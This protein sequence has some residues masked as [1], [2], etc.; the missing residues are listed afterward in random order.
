MRKA[1]LLLVVLAAFATFYACGGD[2]TEIPKQEIDTSD[3]HFVG[4][5]IILET[6]NQNPPPGWVFGERP[7]RGVDE[8]TGE[9]EMYFYAEG[10]SK[11][12]NLAERSARGNVAAAA[13]ESI[14]KNVLSQFAE[15]VESWGAEEDEEVEQVRMSLVAFKSKVK[16]V[17]QHDAGQYAYH[18]EKVGALQGD[19]CTRDRSQSTNLWVAVLRQAI[20]YS[21]YQKMRAEAFGDAAANAG[22]NERQ[23][24]M[25]RR[26]EEAM[27]Q[28]DDFY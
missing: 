13:A 2:E 26:A 21:D 8:T 22:P 17:G 9:P 11:Q 24:E 23:Q 12:K 10:R 16:V 28:L 3:C 18:I 25:L 15:A 14:T 19:N 27:A 5:E 7:W 1:L 6:P 4:Q 20:A